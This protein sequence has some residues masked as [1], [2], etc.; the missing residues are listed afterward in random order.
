M[1]SGTRASRAASV[2]SRP[3]FG[4]WVWTMSGASRRRMPTSCHSVRRSAPTEK[5]RCIGTESARAPSS[6]AIDSSSAPGE[7][8]SVTSMPRAAR[9]AGWERRKFSVVGT[10][11]A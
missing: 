5:P 9:C 4:V 7:D 11:V 10:V 2:T 3:A 6:S 1:H 8:R